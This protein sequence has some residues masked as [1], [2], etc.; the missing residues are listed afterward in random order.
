MTKPSRTSIFSC[1]RN[2]RSRVFWRT[3]SIT[4]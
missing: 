1:S 3:S 2:R 4:M